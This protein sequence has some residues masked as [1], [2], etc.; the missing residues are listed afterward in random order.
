MVWKSCVKF[1]RTSEFGFNTSRIFV[2]AD[3]TSFIILP[4]TVAQLAKS[5]PL[6]GVPK[7]AIALVYSR[8]RFSCC[9]ALLAIIKA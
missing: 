2:F 7:N 9:S 5:D 4:A 6:C 1:S 3:L 8:I